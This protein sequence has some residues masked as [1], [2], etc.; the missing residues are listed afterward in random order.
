MTPVPYN[1]P[2]QPGPGYDYAVDQA[3][4]A[5]RPVRVAVV[6]DKGRDGHQMWQTITNVVVVVTCLA[7]LYALYVVYSGLQALQ[8]GLS[9]VTGL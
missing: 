2:A 9:Q 7:F 4:A 1:P 5:A 8:D 3:A 6:E